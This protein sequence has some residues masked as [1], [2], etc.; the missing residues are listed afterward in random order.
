[1]ARVN[2]AGRKP[3]RMFGVASATSRGGSP[4]GVRVKA[5]ASPPSGGR[6]RSLETPC[7]TMSCRYGRPHRAR[8]SAGRHSTAFE[9]SPR[10][11]A[12]GW[13]SAPAKCAI[14]VPLP[15]RETDA[16]TFMRI[17]LLIDRREPRQA[18]PSYSACTLRF[19]RTASF[20]AALASSPGLLATRLATMGLRGRPGPRC[21]TVPGPSCRLRP[22]ALLASKQARQ[23]PD[24]RQSNQ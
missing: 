24:D 9:A 11:T 15:H 17:V 5:E 22:S 6:R 21:A 10:V 14:A 19:L 2:C 7:A 18:M 1:L 4:A 12:R 8:R 13:Q 3:C 20:R 16:A 23:S